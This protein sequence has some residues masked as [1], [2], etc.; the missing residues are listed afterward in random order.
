MAKKWAQLPLVQE[1][2]ANHFSTGYRSRREQNLINEIAYRW[3]VP[4]L[5]VKPAADFNENRFRVGPQRIGNA[6]LPRPRV[7]TATLSGS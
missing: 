1:A 5:N 2:R 6:T 3:R 7:T 4:R